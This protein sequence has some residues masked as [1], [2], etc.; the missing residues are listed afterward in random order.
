MDEKTEMALNNKYR[1]LFIDDEDANLRIFRSTFRWE[2]DVITASSAE[3]AK[4]ILYKQ[5]IDLIITDQRM[6][7]VTGI[8]FLESIISDFP[9]IPRIIITGYTDVESIIEAVNK[10]KIFQYINK[11]WKKD[12]VQIVIEK[13]LEESRLKS[14][15]KQLI[16]SLKESN[17]Q[18]KSALKE[19]DNF[20]YKASHDLMS[21][22]TSILGLVNLAELNISEDMRYNYVEKIGSTASKMKYFLSHLTLINTVQDR[23]I[24]LSN[25]DMKKL[26]EDCN[27]YSTETFQ[28][29]TEIE[30]DILC[31]TD[32]DLLK[33]ALKQILENSIR[34]AHPLKLGVAQI[35][36][37]NIPEGILISIY[38]NGI[39][40]NKKHMEQCF[41]IFF[42]GENS[43]GSGIGL[44]IAKRVVE[45]LK[46][47]IWMTE[48]LN[49][50]VIVN[51]RLPANITEENSGECIVDLIQEP[52]YLKGE[53]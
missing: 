28:I 43:E 44:Y 51:I 33:I 13:A 52:T 10:G 9:D 11:P 42:K 8:E 6:P 35:N 47:K 48:G 26:F 12:E 29:K 40:V 21:P 46:G 27:S 14:K 3:Q 25:V 24:E 50:G 49:K 34:F 39:G 4:E 22:I 16:H 1:I 2:Y 23:E 53:I 15:N 45:K 7:G 31:T 20:I 37:T 36:V 17:L 41:N 38:D 19:L 5:K 30:K 32:E 18:L